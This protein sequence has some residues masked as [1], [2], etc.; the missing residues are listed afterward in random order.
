MI[1]ITDTL[2]LDESEIREEFIRGAGP[3]GQNVNKVET[4]VRLTH[5]PAGIGVTC[6][7]ER[8]QLKNRQKA[9]KV[10]RARLYEQRMGEQ[11]AEISAAR[12]SM[13][14]SGD[15]SDKI[16]TY[17]FPQNR[18]TDHR[19]GLTLYNLSDIVNGT[20]EDLIDKLKVADRTAKLQE[21]LEGTS[22]A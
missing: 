12:K 22:R 19:I 18:L 15:R 4:A 17:N 5:M 8:S 13:V 14:G 16:R 9:M 10:L 6:Q 1:Q 2:A 3:G 21:G 20:L 11:N 7:E